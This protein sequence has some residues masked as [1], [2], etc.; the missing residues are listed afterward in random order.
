MGLRVEER[1][2]AG[3]EGDEVVVHHLVLRGS[4][5][6]IGRHL[7]ELV[8]ARYGVPTPAG[9]DRP[10]VRE[11]REWL[12]THVPPLHERMRGVAEAL[13]VQLDDDA[14]DLGALGIPASRPYVLELHPEGGRP[15]LAVCAFDLL[16]GALD[17]VNAEGLVVVAAPGEPAAAAPPWP[18]AGAGLDEL[19]VVRWLLEGCA[20]AAEARTALREAR[21]RRA[22]RPARW[23]VTDRHGDAFACDLPP[24]Q[25]RVRLAPTPP[26]PE[27]SAL[28]AIAARAFEPA[29][30]RGLRTLWHGVYDAVERRLTA[31]F[32]VGGRPGP[33][34]AEAAEAR[35]QLS[36]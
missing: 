7:G 17:G 14:H 26:R 32:L 31:R 16:G 4:D 33:R 15:S 9:R 18:G 13:G 10:R 3:G 35:F 27:E 21:L 30:A 34:A 36:A 29:E 6:A 23:L 11:Q 8:S 19:Q 28:A 1:I 2:V 20:T 5:R 25:D 24:G 12:R 22:A